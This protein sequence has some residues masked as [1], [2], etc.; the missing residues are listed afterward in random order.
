[1]QSPNAP[2]LMTLRIIVIAMIVGVAG[3]TGLFVAMASSGR[4][5]VSTAPDAPFLPILAA[6]C[7]AVVPGYILLRGLI[8]RQAQRRCS[9]VESEPDIRN[10]LMMQY[11]SVTVLGAGMAEGPGLFGAVI[12]LLTQN[13]LALIA[14]A[15][16]VLVMLA[17]FPT[18]DRFGGFSITVTGRDYSMR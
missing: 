16:A 6:I 11:F 17:M 10:V 14:P 13:S 15:L 12:Y 2:T 5:P 3:I 9:Q 1:M 7:V 4:A 18:D 8:V